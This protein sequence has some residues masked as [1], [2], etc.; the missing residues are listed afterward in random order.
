MVKNGKSAPTTVSISS[1][2]ASKVTGLTNTTRMPSTVSSLTT[3]NVNKMIE[4]N[5]EKTSKSFKYKN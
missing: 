4:K 3:D 1:S 2:K 5:N